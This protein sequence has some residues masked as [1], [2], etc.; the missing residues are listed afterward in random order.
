LKLTVFPTA[1]ESLGESG[2]KRSKIA[3]TSPVKTLT[4][5]IVLPSGSDTR[6]EW[7]ANWHEQHLDDGQ[8]R[9]VITGGD[10]DGIPVHPI[11]VLEST[12]M[13]LTFA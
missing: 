2:V 6:L 13:T 8:Q 12:L 3:A 1:T 10:L 11:M 9:F 5:V 7:L 4:N